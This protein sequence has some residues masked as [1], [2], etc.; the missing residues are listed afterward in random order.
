MYGGSR[1]ATV[2]GTPSSASHE[3]F[4]GA[5]T[6]GLVNP[7]EGFVWFG[8]PMSGSTKEKR[9]HRGFHFERTDYWVGQMVLVASSPDTPPFVARIANAYEKSD[10]RPYVRLAW[11]NRLEELPL[12]PEYPHRPGELYFTFHEDENP[13]ES[14]VAPC[15]VFHIDDLQGRPRDFHP[16][17]FRFFWEFIF[18][19]DRTEFVRVP[20]SDA[21]RTRYTMWLALNKCLREKPPARP[22]TNLIPLRDPRDELLLSGSSSAPSHDPPAH[23]RRRRSD[24]NQAKSTSFSSVVLSSSSSSHLSPSSSHLS[25]SVATNTL[26]VSPFRRASRS[27]RK[28]S[29]MVPSSMAQRRATPSE[30]STSSSSSSAASSS[31]DATV[32]SSSLMSKR[33]RSLASE[34]DDA[35]RTSGSS[36]RHEPEEEQQKETVGKKKKRKNQKKGRGQKTKKQKSHADNGDGKG[37]KKKRR[38]NE[39]VS[40]QSGKKTKKNSTKRKRT[41]AAS[42]TAIAASSSN[43]TASKSNPSS[44]SKPAQPAVPAEESDL[45]DGPPPSPPPST[46]ISTSS[47]SK[48]P[49]STD[50][51][52][53]RPKKP[54]RRATPSFLRRLTPAMTNALEEMFGKRSAYDVTLNHFNLSNPKNVFC[55]KHKEKRITVRIDRD[56]MVL[57]AYGE[58]VKP[59]WV[60][61]MLVKAW[62]MTPVGPDGQREPR[63]MRGAQPGQ[64]RARVRAS[65]QAPTIDDLFVDASL[66]YSDE[67]DDELHS[68]AEAHQ[69][70]VFGTECDSSA[71]LTRA[72]R[73]QLAA[74]FISQRSHSSPGTFRADDAEDDELTDEETDSEG[75]EMPEKRALPAR[76]ESGGGGGGGGGG[77]TDDMDVDHGDLGGGGDAFSIDDGEGSDLAVEAEGRE[78]DDAGG[79]DGEYDSDVNI[80][81]DY[82]GVPPQSPSPPVP[83]TLLSTAL[84]SSSSSSSSCLRR[85]VQEDPREIYNLLCE[86]LEEARA[87]LNRKLDRW[88]ESLEQRLLGTGSAADSAA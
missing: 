34:L 88:K 22:E 43:G 41:E 42:S 19:H 79:A 59:V 8:P 33:K 66:L 21:E 36:L 23:S 76:S 84:S 32:S 63:P 38:K 65:K 5:K 45:E 17:E 6:N 86:E 81:E 62:E 3:E 70:G 15:E 55:A 72:Q 53:P 39:E 78:H 48:S 87:F 28:S 67:D 52:Q 20:Y 12:L 64:A 73:K 27:M 31:T 83:S 9:L 10:C 82:S 75:S 85:G 58:D 1:V 40:E 18:Y 47:R 25:P 61:T 80:G 56:T 46:S 74:V 2:P 50:Q 44:S 69:D 51:P 29:P 68:N 14:I 57:R 35:E 13:V 30:P 11:F 4:L 16:T 37:K 77:G 49:A 26:A 7:Y 24:D 60:E 71:I 54:E